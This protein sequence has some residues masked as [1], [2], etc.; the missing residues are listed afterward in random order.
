MRLWRHWAVLTGAFAALCWTAFLGACRRH[1]LKLTEIH[2]SVAEGKQ[3]CEVVTLPM[4]W[5]DARFP[6]S[7]LSG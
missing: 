7:A 1:T 5:L 2:I 4:G 3:Y 6:I